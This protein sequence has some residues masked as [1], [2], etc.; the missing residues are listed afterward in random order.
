MR[1]VYALSIL[2][3]A[4]LPVRAA[5][6]SFLTSD[7]VRLHVIEAG[8]AT[9]P[10]IVFVPG[11]TMPAWIFQAQIAAF[12]RSYRVIAL[13]PRGQGD[14][15]IPPG[16]YDHVRRGQDIG[17]LI[18]ALGGPPVLLVGWSLGVLDSL[19]YVAQAGDA[20]L[21]GMVLI[22]N[23]VGEDPAPVP[24]RLPA[25]RGPRVEREEQMRR[26]VRGMFRSDPGP[27]YLA[28]LTNTALRTP[29]DAAA[30]LSNYKVPRVFWRDAIYSVQKPILYVVRP[31][32]AGQA[33]NLAARHPVA[34]TAVFSEAG[35]ALF[36]DEPGRFN[37]LMESFIRRRVWP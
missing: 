24:S 11:W 37:T 3:L 10:A 31:R 7:G 1:A 17:D 6:M 30:A 21:A 14:S 5:D 12:A 29:P 8:P 9:A 25:R 28:R 4:A 19:A 13:D 36:V 16:G 20:R 32:F 15:E 22:D 33:G 34:E 23:S 2:I 18:A 35:H 27:A 26:F